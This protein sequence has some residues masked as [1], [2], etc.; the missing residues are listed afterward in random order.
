MICSMVRT[1][2]GQKRR[3]ASLYGTHSLRLAGAR[4]A[5][6]NVRLVGVQYY[7]GAGCMGEAVVAAP[8]RAPREW[9]PRAVCDDFSSAEQASR[10]SCRPVALCTRPRPPTGHRSLRIM[11]ALIL[12]SIL[13]V[14]AK[15]R[16]RIGITYTLQGLS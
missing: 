9:P 4:L 10:P 6:P 14:Y 13:F 2:A 1:D 15:T 16:I 11:S 7:A 3:A 8:G 5:K 12:F